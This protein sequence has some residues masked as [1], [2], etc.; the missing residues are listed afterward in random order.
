LKEILSSLIGASERHG[1]KH[2][3]KLKPSIVGEKN[4]NSQAEDFIMKHIM[5]LFSGDALEF[6]ALTKM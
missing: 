6:L 2:K 3:K 5:N 1:R 4:K